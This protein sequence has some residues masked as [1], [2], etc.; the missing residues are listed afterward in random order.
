MGLQSKGHY[1]TG[2]GLLEMAEDE[3][4]KADNRDKPQVSI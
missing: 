2:K 4:R 3:T 1:P